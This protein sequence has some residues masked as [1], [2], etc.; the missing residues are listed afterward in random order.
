MSYNIFIFGV[1]SFGADLN[2]KSEQVSGSVT[3]KRS[4]IHSAPYAL[5]IRKIIYIKE[6]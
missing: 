3:V 1:V 5:C 6:R 2:S 4:Y